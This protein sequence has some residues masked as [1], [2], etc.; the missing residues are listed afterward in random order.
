MTESVPVQPAPM[1]LDM[2]PDIATYV[3][4]LEGTVAALCV[5]EAK[6]RAFLE[7]LTGEPWEDTRIDYDGNMIRD[8]AVSAL[9]RQTGM[10]RTKAVVLVE[11]RWQAR[12]L[13]KEQVVPVAIPVQEFIAGD[14]SNR[15]QENNSRPEM[16]ER[17]RAWRERQ[18]A[19]AADLDSESAHSQN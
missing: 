7:M 18:L 9:V 15:S 5:N 17:F 3:G 6:Y 14:A 16:S 19:D 8:L 2:S 12:N 10:D 4:V 1:P 13:P 11:K